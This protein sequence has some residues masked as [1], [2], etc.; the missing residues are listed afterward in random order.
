MNQ[1]IE[2]KGRESTEYEIVDSKSSPKPLSK[3]MPKLR[4]PKKKKQ[5]KKQA[6]DNP[7][8]MLKEK[9]ADVDMTGIIVEKY[10]TF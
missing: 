7:T 10:L 2:S 4:D 5:D 6:F 1:F 9:A 3:N 8:Y